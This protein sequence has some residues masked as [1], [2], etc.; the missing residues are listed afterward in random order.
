MALSENLGVIHQNCPGK[1]G[2]RDTPERERRE[3]E[4]R[5]KKSRAKKKHE[6]ERERETEAQRATKR[7]R[8]FFLFFRSLLSRVFS[9]SAFVFFLTLFFD[10]FFSPPESSALHQTFKHRSFRT[11]VFIITPFSL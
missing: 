4:S 11:L 9:L 1:E 7:E 2:K 5:A 10:F 3:R 8:A 6:R